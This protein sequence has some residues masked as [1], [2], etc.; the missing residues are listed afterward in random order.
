MA[1]VI[2]PE[3]L[4]FGTPVSLTVGGVE[5][6]ATTEPPTWEFEVEEYTP[7]FQGAGGP[8][9]GTKVIR[10]VRPRVNL[11]INEITAEKMAWALGNTSSAVASVAEVGGGGYADT[12][13][14]G[15]PSDIGDQTIIVTQAEAA[16]NPPA[17]NDFIRIGAVGPTAE[18][19]QITAIDVGTNTLTLNRPLAFAH[20]AATTVTETVGD[21]RTTISFR[22]G[23]VPST[24]YRDVVLTG[25]GLDGRQMRVELDDCASSENQ[26]LSFADDDITGL[27]LQLEAHYDPEN[28]RVVPMRVVLL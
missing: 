26:E 25:E 3:E 22:I 23:R 28:P 11:R 5:A 24:D 2:H 8:V 1:T 13:A 4:F 21:G 19:R 20:A 16:A 17:V 6:G 7:E 12:I 15:E 27:D 18:Y 9:K 14:A 10:R